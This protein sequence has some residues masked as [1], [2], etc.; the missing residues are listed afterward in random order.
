[1]AKKIEKKPDVKPEKKLLS[2]RGNEVK[3]LDV[4]TVPVDKFGQPLVGEKFN[5]LG[6]GEVEGF[7]PIIKA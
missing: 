5:K 3:V 1:M 2:E 4:G 6:E 7:D